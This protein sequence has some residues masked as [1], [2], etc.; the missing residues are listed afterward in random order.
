MCAFSS[1]PAPSRPHTL[2][3]TH[4]F[5]PVPRRASPALHFYTLNLMGGHRERWTEVALMGADVKPQARLKLMS[6]VNQLSGGFQFAFLRA[7]FSSFFLLICE[8]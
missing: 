5:P 3:D 6:G 4:T 7:A 1:P 2:S 8:T